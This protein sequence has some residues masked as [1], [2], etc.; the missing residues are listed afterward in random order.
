M[1][2][3]AEFLIERRQGQLSA[4]C[5]FQIGR[6]IECEPEAVGTVR[7]DGRLAS[8]ACPEQSPQIRA[9][10]GGRFFVLI[11]WRN[12]GSGPSTFNVRSRQTD[13]RPPSTYQSS[14]GRRRSS[15]NRLRGQGKAWAFKPL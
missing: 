5:E 4:L 6:V 11:P 15:K 14:P 1:R 8:G 2:G 13:W 10:G 9:R 3:G 7:T 12:C